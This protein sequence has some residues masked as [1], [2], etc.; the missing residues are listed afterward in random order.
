MQSF[1]PSIGDRHPAVATRIP[2]V[3][4]CQNWLRK[5][6]ALA[7]LFVATLTLTPAAGASVIPLSAALGTNAVL[8]ARSVGAS[9][10]GDLIDYGIAHWRDPRIRFV[11]NDPANVVTDISDAQIIGISTNLLS[12][13]N[14][15][16]PSPTT[17]A[18]LHKLD[19]IYPGMG[20][21][22]ALLILTGVRTVAHLAQGAAAYSTFGG[23]SPQLGLAVGKLNE[24]IPP[25][26]SAL[27]SFVH[28]VLLAD[29][30]PPF[31]RKLAADY[32][33]FWDDLLIGGVLAIPGDELNALK[34]IFELANVSWVTGSAVATPLALS[35]AGGAPLADN[36]VPEPPAAALALLAIVGVCWQ[37]RRPVGRGRR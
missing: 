26:N 18:D 13:L 31:L 3:R 4:W 21:S 25:F 37:R 19:L 1:E 33:Q 2:A 34:Q 20:D 16:S 15:A 24:D 7:V 17:W 35:V 22:A 36:G 12:A 6:A 23:G 32:N 11:A 9:T 10:L 28:Y 30:T 5:A 27:T 14:S 8:G 29:G